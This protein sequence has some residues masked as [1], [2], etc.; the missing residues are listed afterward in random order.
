MKSGFILLFFLFFLNSCH[1]SLLEGKP[2]ATFTWTPTNLD[3]P[4]TVSFKSNSINATEF[5]W[6]FGDG[7]TST[8]ENPTNTYTVAG[9]YEVNLTVRNPSAPQDIQ[10]A[11]TTNILTVQ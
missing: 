7:N 1:K 2:V 3:A 8:L 11:T 4:V 5:S 10:Y 9:T 6:D